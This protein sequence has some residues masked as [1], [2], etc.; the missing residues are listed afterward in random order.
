MGRSIDNPWKVWAMWIL[1]SIQLR[2]VRQW[3]DM[4][5]ET[6]L[7]TILETS[8]SKWSGVAVCH[9]WTAVRMMQ[10]MH[11]VRLPNEITIGLALSL[12]GG[13]SHS[14]LFA[15]S[16]ARSANLHSLLWDQGA[17]VTACGRSTKWQLAAEGCRTHYAASR[18]CVHVLK[19]LEMKQIFFP[20]WTRYQQ[21]PLTFNW[22]KSRALWT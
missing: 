1:Q 10:S 8:E 17:W 9:M 22:P 6:S 20:T 18:C 11:S 16:V 15:R 13:G 14:R 7:E 21:D 2:Q 3:E 12:G 19:I 4:G 5:S